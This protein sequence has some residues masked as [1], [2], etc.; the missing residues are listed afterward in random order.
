LK[1][2]FKKINEGWKH[3]YEFKKA[4]NAMMQRRKQAASKHHISLFNKI[5][6]KFKPK[7]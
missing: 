4:Y 3:K 1:S 6:N 5:K 2:I 7:K